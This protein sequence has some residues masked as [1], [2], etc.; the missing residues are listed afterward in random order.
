MDGLNCYALSNIETGT[1]ITIDY[2]WDE[3]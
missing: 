2:G 1:E 3:S